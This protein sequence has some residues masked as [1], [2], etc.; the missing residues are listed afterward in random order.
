[1]PEIDHDVMHFIEYSV[2]SWDNI[3]TVLICTKL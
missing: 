1:M 2:F 3:D